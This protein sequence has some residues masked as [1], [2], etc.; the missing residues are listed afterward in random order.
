MVRNRYI[1]LAD[2]LESRIKAGDLSPGTR[3]ATHRDFAEKHGIALATATCTYNELRR[4][5]LI[6]GEAGRGMFVRDGALPITLGFEQGA[7]K[8]LVDLVFNIPG[9]AADSKVLRDGLDAQGE[10][11]DLLQSLYHDRPPAVPLNSR[12]DYRDLLEQLD[13]MP[14]SP[15]GDAQHRTSSQTGLL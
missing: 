13:G 14:L 11:R 10:Y 1:E 4:R 8:C 12:E 2:M 15:T 5:G 6:L 3:L 7:S 9:S